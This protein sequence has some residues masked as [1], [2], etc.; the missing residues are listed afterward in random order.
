[1][2]GSE[3]SNARILVGE[4]YCRAVRYEVADAFSYAMNCHC[5]DCRRTT[6]AAFKPFA[7]IEQGKLRI[8][9][10]ENQRTIYGDDTTHDAHCARP[11][12]RCFIPGCARENGSMSPWEPWSMPPRSDR[13]PTFSWA[14]RRLGTRLRIICRNIGATWEM[15]EGTCCALVSRRTAAGL[16]RQTKGAFRPAAGTTFVTSVTSVRDGPC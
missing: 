3:N 5:S 1:M 16:A 9:S 6:G 7:G 14:R 8:V 12:A 4:C 15:P 10:G 11:A 13:A 2:T